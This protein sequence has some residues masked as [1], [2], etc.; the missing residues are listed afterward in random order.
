MIP[1]GIQVHVIVVLS[2]VSSDLKGGALNTLIY[3][4][5]PQ[6]PKH[7][8]FGYVEGVGPYIRVFTGW[9]LKSDHTNDNTTITCT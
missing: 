7:A 4:P 5:T 2:F 6:T 3:G 8:N 9:A 1:N